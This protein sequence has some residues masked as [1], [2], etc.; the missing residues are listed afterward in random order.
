MHL[1][2]TNIFEKLLDILFFLTMSKRNNLQVLIRCESLVFVKLFMLSCPQF[3]N[4]K[5]YSLFISCH[6]WEK[7]C[8]IVNMKLGEVLDY[9]NSVIVEHKSC[10]ICQELGF[11]VW[12]Q[13]CPCFPF[14]YETF[15]TCIGR[16]AW[17]FPIILTCHL[18]SS[19]KHVMCR[20]W[21]MIGLFQDPSSSTWAF[22]IPACLSH[23]W[24]VKLL[25]LG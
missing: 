3:G 17:N 1:F 15:K 6:N 23:M 9:E 19:F 22:W 14:Y 10:L 8:C 18:S 12:L 13:W 7:F 2:I 11:H 25:K 24:P 16:V 20:V 4:F 21:T 5:D